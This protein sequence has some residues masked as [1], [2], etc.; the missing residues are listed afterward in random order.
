VLLPPLDGGTGDPDGRTGGTGELVGR[1]YVELPPMLDW[2]GLD[3]EGGCK[4]MVSV[5][6][7]DVDPDEKVGFLVYGD[8]V[9]SVIVWFVIE[10]VR[11]LESVGLLIVVEFFEIVY[12]VVIEAFEV[13]VLICPVD[14][15]VVV[16]LE[17]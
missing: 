7:G 9:D 15:I 8:E 5:L 2:Y 10:E 11:L 4:V 6:Q 14:L 13:F 17:V 1:M 3:V 16:F 12:G